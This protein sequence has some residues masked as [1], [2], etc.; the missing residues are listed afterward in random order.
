[1]ADSSTSSSSS[2]SSSDIGMVPPAPLPLKKLKAKVKALEASL[3]Q[4]RK[5]KLVDD[6]LHLR[7]FEELGEITCGKQLALED[8]EKVKK[9]IV[10]LKKK[11]DTVKGDKLRFQK[12]FNSSVKRSGGLLTDLWEVQDE[13][14]D[15]KMSKADLIGESVELSDSVTTAEEK[16]KAFKAAS[17]VKL[18]DS[19]KQH[20]VDLGLVKRDLETAKEENAHLEVQLESA[21]KEIIAEIKAR[22]HEGPGPYMGC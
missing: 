22:Y 6:E 5:R 17:K 16:F 14:H 8:L 15:V 9:E 19:E 21:R 7:T 12:L 2:S 10:G 11:M 3:R 13:L 18:E 20:A 1:M 4:A